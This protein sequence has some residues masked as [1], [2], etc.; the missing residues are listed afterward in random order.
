M[1]FSFVAPT[2]TFENWVWQTMS[3]LTPAA[4]GMVPNAH[5]YI[6]PAAALPGEIRYIHLAQEAT[7]SMGVFVLPPGA[8]IP[9]HDHPDM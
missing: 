4:L 8:C 3:M 9:L 2:P 7:F 6:I 1:I 5:E